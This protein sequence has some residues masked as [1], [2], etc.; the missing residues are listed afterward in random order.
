MGQKPEAEFETCL[1]SFLEF[2]A[3]KF[4]KNEAI[5]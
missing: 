5:L 4:P 2:Q 1:W 3:N